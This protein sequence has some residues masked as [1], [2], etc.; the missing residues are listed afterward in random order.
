MVPAS[1]QEGKEAI[2]LKQSRKRESVKGRI[3]SGMAFPAIFSGHSIRCFR[4]YVRE[5]RIHLFV[6]WDGLVLSALER[7]SSN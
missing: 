7:L 2:H 4:Q 6:V 3:A 5:A 1:S